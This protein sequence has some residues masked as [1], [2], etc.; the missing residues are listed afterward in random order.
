MTVYE[1]L[2]KRPI[3]RGLRGSRRL[4]TDPGSV[5]TVGGLFRTSTS[6]DVG[7]PWWNSRAVRYLSK[8]AQPGACAFEWGSGG[9][10]VWLASR[11]VVT[12]SVEHDPEWAAKV[13]A[14]CPNADVRLIKGLT[15]GRLRSEPQLPDQGIHFFDDYVAAIDDVQDESLD[16]V[17]VDGMCRVEC[18]RRGAR[19]VKSGGILI[20]DDTNFRFLSPAK[21]QLRGWRKVRLAGLKWRPLDV[22]ETTFFHKTY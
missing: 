3:T 8:C 13:T 12:T 20:M 9:S 16:I 17:I 22:T 10:T 4:I 7:E 1:Q 21:E 19:K 14:R 11:G 5:T 6:W 18:V 2:V 15:E